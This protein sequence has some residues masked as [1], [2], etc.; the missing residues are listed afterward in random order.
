MDPEDSLIYIQMVSSKLILSLGAS[1]AIAAALAD[2]D[3]STPEV[4]KRTFTC[5]EADVDTLIATLD[6][7]CDA[8]LGEGG[9]ILK[10]LTT[11]SPLGG[12]IGEHFQWLSGNIT[13]GGESCL[14]SSV[15]GHIQQVIK[16]LC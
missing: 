16:L 13:V 4:F 5:S 8:I 10:L 9:T 7:I 3:A 2:A 15:S 12:V 1:T 11:L 6:G 14:D